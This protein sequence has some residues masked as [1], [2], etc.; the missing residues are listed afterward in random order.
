MKPVKVKQNYYKFS[1]QKY[2]RF[3]QTITNSLSKSFDKKT[4]NAIFFHCSRILSIDELL[5]SEPEK[6]LKYDVAYHFFY[7]LGKQLKDLE[8]KDLSVPFFEKS[9]IIVLDVPN[10]RYRFL[11][12]NKDKLLKIDNGEIKIE[13]PYQ[14]NGFFSPEL[15]DVS[16]L[17]A[18]ISCQSG[19]FSLASMCA[20]LLNDK[21]ITKEMIEKGFFWKTNTR[22]ED[23]HL[24]ARV[25]LLDLINGTKLFF[26]LER[27]LNIPTEDRYYFFI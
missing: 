8:S 21:K 5:K 14:N 24:S 26:A 18:K 23:D 25:L 19:I 4:N 7:D 27:C 11:F 15:E 9:D 3:W 22:G 1:F 2:D 13:I 17:P 10:Q 6:R 20:S 12:I 16:V